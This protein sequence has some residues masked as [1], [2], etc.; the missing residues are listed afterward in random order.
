MK[1]RDAVE[2]EGGRT[3]TTER[4]R[5]WW[6]GEGECEREGGRGERERERDSNCRTESMIVPSV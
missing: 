4:E 6:R 3:G 5:V 2:G 1:E